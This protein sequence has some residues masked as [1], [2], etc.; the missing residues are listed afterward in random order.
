[1]KLIPLSLGKF[2]MVSDHRFEELSKYK[3]YARFGKTTWYACTWIRRPMNKCGYGTLLMHRLILGLAHGD[4]R[5][6][7]HINFDGLDN[8]DENLR[9]VSQEESQRHRRKVKPGTT[10]FK[11]V[12]NA[13]NATHPFEANIRFGCKLHYLGCYKTAEEAAHAYDEAALKHFGEFAHLNYPPQQNHTK[14]SSPSPEPP[15]AAPLAPDQPEVLAPDQPEGDENP[16]H[17][18]GPLGPLKPSPE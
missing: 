15:P 13:T 8:T 11:G 14:A 10:K 7:D 2:A 3:W 4:K 5:H 1:M 18:D 6:A 9:I 17:P 12:K 16:L